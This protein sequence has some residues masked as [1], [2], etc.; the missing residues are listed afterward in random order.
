MK[1]QY[2]KTIY[3]DEQYVAFP[4]LAKLKNDQIICAFRHA[5][6]RQKEYGACTHVDPLAKDVFITSPDGGKTFDNVLHTIVDD[7]MM[8]DQDPC[9]NVLSDGRIIVTYF[10]W[11]L[12]PIGEGCDKWGEANFKSFGRSLWN[13]YDCYTDGAAYSISDDN[14]K[15]WKH[16]PALHMEG[17][18]ASGGV[19]GNI[20]EL[21]SGELLLP[22]YGSLH[23]GELARAGLLHS[24]DRGETWSH[25]SDM[26]FDPTHTKNFLEPG[27]YYT[28]K[29]KLVGLFR[30]QTDYRLPG[31]EF[32]DTYL[33]LHIAVS[34]DDGRTFE[35][36][37]EI[38]GLWGSSPFHAL[39]LKDDRVLLTYGYR[40]EPYGIRARICDPEL[41]HIEDAEEI[42]LR[43]D[44]LNGDLGYP[45]SIL[46]EDGT[47][48]VSYYISGKDGI[49]TID[50]TALK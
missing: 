39:R 10:R 13:K 11:A 6:E 35:P 36:V 48:L 37:K 42:I 8:S 4:N 28:P 17:M 14:G 20:V 21:P 22:I 12:C 43:D 29:G 9:V 44:G 30:T 25:L 1:I 49:R 2:T 24:T 45:N 19:R 3:R 16:Y 33:N 7:E 47:A 46:L 27:L 32:D 38:E 34:H 15:T 31:V 50:V 5:P 41:E 23:V 40:R 18:P 26:A